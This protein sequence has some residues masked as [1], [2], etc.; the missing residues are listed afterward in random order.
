MVLK[1]NHHNLSPRS[2]VLAIL[3]VFLACPLLAAEKQEDVFRGIASEIVNGIGKSGW[4]PEHSGKLNSALT[5]FRRAYDQS[6]KKKL[7]IAIWPFDEN[8]VPIPKAAAD[9]FNDTLL[10]VLQKQ[11]GSRYEFVARDTLKFLILDMQSTG[12]LDAADGN[13]INALMKGA[14][15]INILIIGKVRLDG[16]RVVLTYKAVRTDGVIA[17][18]TTPRSLPY[19]AP[20]VAAKSID[21]AVKEVAR[22]FVDQVNDMEALILGGI[23]YGN[24]GAQ[25]PFGRRL[26]GLVSTALQRQFSN[27]ISGNKLR[28]TSL[29]SPVWEKRGLTVDPRSLSDRNTGGGK[30]TYI[31]SGNYWELTHAV[32]VRLRLQNNASQSVS[33]VGRIRIEDTHGSRLKPGADLVD[34]RANDGL[35]PIAFQLTTGRGRDPAYKIGEKINLMIRLDRDAWVYCFYRQSDASLIQIFPNPH[36]Q[37]I[38]PRLTGGTLHTI[39]GEKTFPFNFRLTEPLGYEL[40]KCFATSRDVTSELPKFLRGVSLDPLPSGSDHRLSGVFRDLPNVAV[41]EQSLLVTVT[42]QE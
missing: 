9:E 11:A 21:Q 33:W 22:Y 37:L 39:P 4:P 41:S 14:G 36:M 29:K 12:A 17:A 19:S 15:S 13:P 42:A 30:G 3:F 32:E 23:R 18:T 1:V 16:A 38:V 28:V 2:P 6:R 31:L 10:G 26:Q 24:S 20:I 34:L 25:P 8:E 27:S 40:L 7:R 35:G 5:Y